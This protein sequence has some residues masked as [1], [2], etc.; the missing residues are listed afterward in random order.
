[1][2]FREGVDRLPRVAGYG[3]G[4]QHL[5]A[6]VA[7]ILARRDNLSRRR[8]CHST[9]V[10][11]PLSGYSEAGPAP[12]R[13]NGKLPALRKRVLLVEGEA[14]RRDLD[15]AI[16]D[17]NLNGEPVYPLADLLVARDVPLIFVTCYGSERLV[18]RFADKPVLQMPIAAGSLKPHLSRPAH[19]GG[20]SVR[21]GELTSG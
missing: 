20:G 10:A 19:P 14:A 8:G 13:A 11:C 17:I 7:G 16:L 3:I 6:R 9:G 21:A 2:R 1:M 12:A 15:G 18:S 5:Q 4:D